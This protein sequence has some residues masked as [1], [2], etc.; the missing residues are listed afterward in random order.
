M[1]ENMGR[2]TQNKNDVPD[3]IWDNW[4]NRQKSVFNK[5]YHE[6]R[7]TRQFLFLPA[8]VRPLSREEWNTYRRNVSISAADVCA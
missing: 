4:S 7:P 5:M 1:Q 6:M 3:H 8:S 2:R